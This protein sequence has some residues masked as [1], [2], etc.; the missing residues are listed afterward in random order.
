MLLY[1]I[2]YCVLFLSYIVL[3]QK[4]NKSVLWIAI[5]HQKTTIQPNEQKLKYKTSTSSFWNTLYTKWLITKFESWITSNKWPSQTHQ[6]TYVTSIEYASCGLPVVD[7]LY[8]AS[9]SLHRCRHRICHSCHTADCRV[10]PGVVARAILQLRTTVSLVPHAYALMLTNANWYAYASGR[11][12]NLGELIN[13][14]YCIM[15]KIVSSRCFN[16]DVA[17]FLQGADTVVE[18]TPQMISSI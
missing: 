5:V 2:L 15:G 16:A 1:C 13:E 12:I 11:Y 18:G 8:M 4:L 14:R 7:L 17:V 6:D 3:I 10:P 9:S